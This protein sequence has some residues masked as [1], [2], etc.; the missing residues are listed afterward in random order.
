MTEN[1]TV[2][3]VGSVNMDLIVRA[4]EMPCPGQTVLGDGFTTNPGGKGANQA[5]AAARLG[6][7]CRLLGRVGR[8]EF[9][10]TL[11][12]ALKGEGIDCTHLLDTDRHPS[13]VAFILVDAQGENSIVVASGANA[14]LTPDDVFA[15]A[16]AFAGADVVLLQLELPLP[17]VRAAVDVARRNGC[18]I[19][20]D[21]A[22]APRRLPPELYN[23]DIISPNVTE[24]ETLTGKRALEERL[25]KHV[26]MDLLAAGA[27]TA[28][29]K[30][31]SRGSLVVANDGH[32]YRVPAYKVSVVDTTAAGDAFTAAMGVALARGQS[33][34]NA[35]RFANAAGAL[36]CT[37][38]GAQS[39]MP[40]AMEVSMLMSDQPMG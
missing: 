25:D 8:D 32:F 9:G 26:A 12:E 35:A 27:K 15:A 24:A 6:A 1:P 34:H 21:P 18:R 11:T 14:Q 3:V 13:G 20:L 40:T 10:R 4:P 39:A 17:T 7:H 30:L 28:V 2:L 33:L 19:I 37:R 23:V 36:A 38:L 5:V 29:L 31:G 16:D 22:P